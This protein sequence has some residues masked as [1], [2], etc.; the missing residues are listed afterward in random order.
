MDAQ[1][2]LG[3][4]CSHMPR[5]VSACLRSMSNDFTMYTHI[6]YVDGQFANPLANFCYSVSGWHYEIFA[7]Y[8]YDDWKTWLDDG[9]SDG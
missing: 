2:D 5:N 3:L 6:V 4:R 7:K 9:R 1:A 8:A